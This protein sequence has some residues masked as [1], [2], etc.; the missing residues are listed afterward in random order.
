M[1][2]ARLI[3]LVLILCAIQ[4]TFLHATIMHNAYANSIIHPNE[5]DYL[6]FEESWLDNPPQMVNYE[7]MHYLSA[8]LVNVTVTCSNWTALG[9]S[10]PPNNQGFAVVNVTN[11]KVTD[12]VPDNLFGFGFWLVLFDWSVQD[13]SLI[14]GSD[15]IPIVGEVNISRG[16]EQ[17]PCWNISAAA[18]VYHVYGK[19]SGILF[20]AECKQTENEW[21]ITLLEGSV[22]SYIIIPEFPSFLILP[23]F[24]I[25]TLLTVLIHRRNAS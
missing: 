9:F 6:L 4:T 24:M 3:R 25:A 10:T 12:Q 15:S 23:L 20:E 13:G 1:I 11:G 14:I 22:N 19:A 18:G 16:G 21:A 2:V 8:D 17:H 7:F 5:G